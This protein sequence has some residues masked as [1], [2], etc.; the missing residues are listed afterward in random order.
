M[1]ET[2]SLA[3]D[4]TR[5][6]Y[7]L[8]KGWWLAAWKP[9]IVVRDAVAFALQNYSRGGDPAEHEAWVTAVAMDLAGWLAGRGPLRL[10]REYSDDDG[11]D[12]LE[13]GSRP[14]MDDAEATE[15]TPAR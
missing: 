2:F 10:V 1:G 6:R 7:W 4:A 13:T 14:W 12:Y 3:D 5:E 15:P 11:L 9:S 8:G